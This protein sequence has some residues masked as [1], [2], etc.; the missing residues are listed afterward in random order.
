MLLKEQKILSEELRELYEQV[1][2]TCCA[3]SGECCELTESE[4]VEGYATMFPLYRAEYVNIVSYVR[5][6]FS[7]VKQQKLLSHT[8]E[9]PQKCPF[10]DAEKRCTIYPV[11]PLICRTYAVMNMQTID[12]AVTRYKGKVPDQWLRNFARREGGMVCPRVV[13]TQSEKLAR[14]VENLVTSAYER[15]LSRL[16]RKT[17]ILETSE[18]KELVRRLI[19]SSLPER[20][21]WGGFNAVT[22]APMGWVK[23]NLR[24]YWKKSELKIM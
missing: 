8:E 2:A 18:R 21:S 15:V 20:W 11:R 12:D 7:E 6:H 14:H 1:P 24:K 13:V 9:R 4:M 19:G 5:K 17:D 23:R 22:F 16:S 3:S 10:L